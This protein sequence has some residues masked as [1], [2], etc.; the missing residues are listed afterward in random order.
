MGT[1]SPAAQ[2]L[3]ESRCRSMLL[4][5]KSLNGDETRPCHLINVLVG[6]GM[7]LYH[8]FKELD[9]GIHERILS[10][11]ALAT[12][13]LLELRYWTT[14]AAASEENIWRIRKDALV[15]A[16]EMLDR[17][18]TAFQANPE[19]APALSAI[20][21]ARDWFEDQCK[22]S[23]ESADGPYIR[24]ANLAQ[25]FGLADEHRTMSSVLS[26]LIHPTGLTICLPS[27]TD[28]S[29]PQLYAAG[30][31][32]FNDS[33]EQLNGTLKKLDLPFLE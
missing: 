15:D 19:L 1:M 3:A 22:Q 20:Q 7:E 24:S 14:F 17:F 4:A 30:C 16:R 9:S 12:R 25:Q 6:L 32:Y 21:Q 31:W 11:S 10:R 8:A 29:F 5:L 28:F 13:N 33:F 2:R 18:T 26:K 27:T 23:G